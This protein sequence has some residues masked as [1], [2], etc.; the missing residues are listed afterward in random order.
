MDTLCPNTIDSYNK[1]SHAQDILSTFVLSQYTLTIH[2][3][4]LHIVC[5]TCII[6]FYLTLSIHPI[7]ITLPNHSHYYCTFPIYIIL[8]LS[9]SNEHII[10]TQIIPAH[11]IL[12]YSISQTF[13]IDLHSNYPFHKHIL[14]IMSS[15][16]KLYYSLIYLFY[17]Y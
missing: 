9:L 11:S 3:Q 12:T 6:L 1:R 2:I 5:T 17:I 8:L 10:L 16:N 15:L 4:C 14:S 13:L 7:L